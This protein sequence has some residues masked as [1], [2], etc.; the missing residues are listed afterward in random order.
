MTDLPPDDRTPAEQGLVRLAERA[1]G[2]LA[3]QAVATEPRAYAVVLIGLALLFVLTVVVAGRFHDERERLAATQFERGR[4]LARSGDPQR[5]LVAYRTALALERNRP[6]VELALALALL[7]LGRA[8][9]AV[10]Y[11]ADV[12]RAD[13]TSGPAN[14]A[15][16][17]AARAIGDLDDAE[18]FYQRAIYGAWPGD[19][20]SPRLDVRFELVELLLQRGHRQRAAGELTQIDAD[21]PDNV[22]VAARLGPCSCRSAR[23]TARPRPCVASWRRGPATAAHGPPSRPPN[24]P[25]AVFQPPSRPASARSRCGPTM[26]RRAGWSRR[27]GSPWIWIRRRAGWPRPSASAGPARS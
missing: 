12:L 13:P 26:G 6:D 14:L 20:A 9:E 5:A 10:T 16:A 11:L 24:W 21:A 18:V 19:A 27:R 4:A 25:S 8:H 22:D 15:R 23:P 7:D 2:T 3:R 1:L 17:R